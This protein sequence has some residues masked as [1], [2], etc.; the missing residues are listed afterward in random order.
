MRAVK[1]QLQLRGVLRKPEKPPARARRDFNEAEFTR[2]LTRNGFIQVSDIHF[3][4][5]SASRRSYVEAVYHTNPIRI[6]RRATLAK[7]IRCKNGGTP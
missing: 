7:L 2:A 6:A 3:T 5:A 1:R 4:D